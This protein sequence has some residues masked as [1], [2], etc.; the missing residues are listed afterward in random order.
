[1]ANELVAGSYKDYVASVLN[2]EMTAEE[3]NQKVK[4]L[5]EIEYALDQASIVAITDQ[6]GSITYVNDLFCE[7]S[8]YSREELIGQNHRILNSGY[9]PKDFFKEMW[10]TIGNGKVWRGEIKNKRKDGSYYWV[11]AT[12]V[13]FLNEKGIPY[14]YISIRTDI[15]KEKELEEEL[16]RGNEKY[17]LIAENSVN[18]ISLINKDGMFH[19]ISPSFNRILQYDLCY[20]ENRNLFEIIHPA[21]LTVFKENVDKALNKRLK[22][23]EMELRIRNS[24]G[25][26]V[27]VETDLSI[28]HQSTYSKEP[29]ILVSMKDISAEKEIEK[30]ILHLS[31]YDPL[32][33][34]PNRLS[35][36]SE[37]RKEML[38][39]HVQSIGIL[40][41]DLDNFKSIN[42]QLGHDSGDI[43]LKEAAEKIKNSIR[44]SDVAA[45]MSGDEFII[46]LRNVKDEETVKTISNRIINSF[47][48]PITVDNKEFIVTCSIG[49]AIYPQ[50][51][52]T[53]EELIKNADKALTHV[54]KGTKN[55]YL[56]FN[57]D[58]ETRSLERRLL[59]NALRNALENGQFFLQF[60]PKM[61]MLSNKLVGMEALVRWKH[62]DLGIISPNKFISIAEEIGLIIPLGE[63]VLREACKQA[64][65]WQEKYHSSLMISVN[66]SVRQLEHPQ[67]IENIKKVLRETKIK[68]Q[69][70]ELE[71]T[72]SI[73]AD[74]QNVVEVLNKI[75]ELG[76]QVSVDDFG[77]GYS[78]LSYLK[79]LPIDTLKIDASFVRD[80]H[81]NEE[82]RAIIIAILNIANSIGLKVIAEGVELQ[83]QIETLCI[84]G[85]QF[86]QGYFFSKPLDKKEFE[87]YIEQCV[88]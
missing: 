59:E 39:S 76:I 33:G 20:L 45:R 37:L 32:T 27:Y 68:P 2:G 78:S 10:K 82:S 47:N 54:K 51:G 70:L 9:H 1:M 86:A 55:D 11:Y 24:C 19:Y 79:H 15:T 30:Q 44:P 26:Y 31:Y 81:I 17:R 40:F 53:A 64:R 83:E 58:I 42:E 8:Q 69:L 63:W 84:N 87:R 73:L 36:I 21:D 25:Q 62:P 14:Q 43:F 5:L 18:L 35:F 48:K 71:V 46:M 52:T 67:F 74:V 75:R 6:K 22:N 49:I 13:P 77:T 16:A 7:L 85:C 66:V 38:K 88:E 4:E 41:L 80:I 28:V 12:I 57:K 29:L 65:I 60:Q 61:N 3:I 72:E 50:H 23:I 56:I 34:F